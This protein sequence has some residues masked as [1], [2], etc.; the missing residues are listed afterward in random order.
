MTQKQKIKEF[1]DKWESCITT[2]DHCVIDTAFRDDLT[3]LLDDWISVPKKCPVCDGK[4]LLPH[5]F[6]STH[7]QGSTSNISDIQCKSCNGTGIV[8]P[9]PPKEK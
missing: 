3:N 2:A 4:G 9:Q 8:Y 5:S 6:Y 1:I 7:N